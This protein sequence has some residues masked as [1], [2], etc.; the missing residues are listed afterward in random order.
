MQNGRRGKKG[1]GPVKGIFCLRTKVL[2]HY[3]AKTKQGKKSKRAI[4]RYVNQTVGIISDAL[5]KRPVEKP[6]EIVEKC[7][8]STA[9]PENSNYDTCKNSARKGKLWR[10]YGAIMKIMLPP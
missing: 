9:I 8:F 10:K 6:V 5:W 2:R 1:T 4:L 7:E 3:F